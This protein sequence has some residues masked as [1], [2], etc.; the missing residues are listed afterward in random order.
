MTTHELAAELLKLPDL[1]LVTEADSAARTGDYVLAS[2]W[3]EQ[4]TVE[5]VTY[6]GFLQVENGERTT[7]FSA[8][9]P[10]EAIVL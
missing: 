1:L 7:M 5:P 6:G 2:L 3:G 4:I 8:G 10:I 9:E